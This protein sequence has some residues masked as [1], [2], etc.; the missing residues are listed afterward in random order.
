MGLS[1]A[2]LFPFRRF[3]CPPLLTTSFSTIKVPGVTVLM[4]LTI[5]SFS[6]I[7]SG[8]VF[9]FVRD[10]PMIGAIHTNNGIRPSWIDNQGIHSQFGT[11]GWVAAALLS[12]SAL[13]FIAAAAAA[14]KPDG[15]PP[16]EFDA[17]L[18]I[19]GFTAPG[20]CFLSYVIFRTKSGHSFNVHF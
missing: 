16:A 6:V 7:T 1:D 17:A 12:F 19:F 3:F 13:A 2:L 11:E 4:F 9:C 14:R 5:L 18:R 10:I 8:T 20:W 15:E